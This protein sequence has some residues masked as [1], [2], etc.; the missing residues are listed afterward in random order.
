MLIYSYGSEPRGPKGSSEAFKMT[1]YLPNAKRVGFRFLALQ[2][3][4]SRT[5][6]GVNLAAFQRRLETWAHREP[7]HEAKGRH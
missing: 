2:Q 1:E 5:K 7:H 3:P 4:E 6:L